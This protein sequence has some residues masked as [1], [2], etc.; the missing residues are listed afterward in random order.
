ML[1]KKSQVGIY[2]I[3]TYGIDGC[4]SSAIGQAAATDKLCF[5]IIGDLA[6]FYDMNAL[7]IQHIGRNLRI[8]LINNRGGGE[9]Y[10]NGS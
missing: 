6:F 9:F 10:Y 2:Y 7:R 5:L 1:L 8:L 4:L 3:G